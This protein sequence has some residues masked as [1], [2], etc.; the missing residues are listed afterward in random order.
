MSVTHESC[1]RNLIANTVTSL[2]GASGYLELQ[3]TSTVAVATLRFASTAFSSAVAGAAT[4]NT[5]T[6]DAAAVGGTMAQASF[7]SSTPS[8]VMTCTVSSS[9]GAGDIKFN[10]VIVGAGQQVSITS[11]SYTA[12][13]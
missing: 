7:M 6:A 9:G 3:T 8:R 10:S 13:T 2:L 5:I 1:T 4:A 12:P 11:L